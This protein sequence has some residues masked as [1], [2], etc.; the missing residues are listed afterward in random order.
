M[1]N[2]F[3]SDP[4]KRGELCPETTLNSPEV[5]IRNHFVGINLVTIVARF[6][7]TISK[8]QTQQ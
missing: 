6:N 3:L 8:I 7:R 2:M 1:S 5:A 4:L